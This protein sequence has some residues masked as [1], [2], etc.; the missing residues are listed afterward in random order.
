MSPTLFILASIPV[1]NGMSSP[2]AYQDLALPQLVPYAVVVAIAAA[3][4]ILAVRRHGK[5]RAELQRLYAQLAGRSIDSEADQL[6][7]PRTEPVSGPSASGVK[8]EG[9]HSGSAPRYSTAPLDPQVA[10]HFFESQ[11]EMNDPRVAL[12]EQQLRVIESKQRLARM[13]SIPLIVL[14]LSV[15]AAAVILTTSPRQATFSA[16][17]PA[18]TTAAGASAEIKVAPQPTAPSLQRIPAS[19]FFDQ[20]VWGETFDVVSPELALGAADNRS[21]RIRPGGI[22]TLAFAQGLQFLDQTGPDLALIAPSG[23]HAHYRILVRNTSAEPWTKIDF[24][25][26][27]GKHD[28]GHHHIERGAYVQIRNEDHEDLLVDAVEA[29]AVQC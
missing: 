3:I 1:A 17:Q 5:N 13:I 8:K 24:G 16:V 20:V 2:S 7:L 4:G 15:V 23:G 26:G 9:G 29:F 10:A 27:S 11:N 28:M 21:A 12:L 25:N 19:A 6:G 18:Q 22:L 14:A